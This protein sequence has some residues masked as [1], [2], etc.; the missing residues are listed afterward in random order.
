MNI[1]RQV[2][3]RSGQFKRFYAKFEV[4]T[5]LLFMILKNSEK[6]GKLPTKFLTIGSAA[7]TRNMS[8]NGNGSMALLL[9]GLNGNIS[10]LVIVAMDMTV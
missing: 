2:S 4:D 9:N 7:Q 3:S 8:L 5:S 1:W 6:F 10:N